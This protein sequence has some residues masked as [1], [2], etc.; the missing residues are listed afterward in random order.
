MRGV[1]A[2]AGYILTEGKY[3]GEDIIITAPALRDLR[4]ASALSYVE[5]ATISR[6]DLDEVMEQHPQ[7]CEAL[8]QGALLLATNRASKIIAEYYRM[9]AAKQRISE[10]DDEGLMCA[11]LRSNP[12][13]QLCTAAASPIDGSSMRVPPSIRVVQV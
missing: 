3:W 11:S 5:V 4:P 12:N 13:R 2:K 9:H 6:T 10:A 1:A 8:R 7:D